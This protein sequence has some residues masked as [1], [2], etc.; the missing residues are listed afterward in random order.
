MGSLNVAIRTPARITIPP[1][2]DVAVM[3]SPSST[4]AT[5]IVATDD[6]RTARHRGQR[7]KL[8]E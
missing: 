6:G 8:V 1:G 3:A 4:A 5:I 2:I 7:C